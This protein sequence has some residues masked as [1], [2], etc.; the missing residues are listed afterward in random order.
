MNDLSEAA[1]AALAILRRAGS[2]PLPE[3]VWRSRCIA[4]GKLATGGIEAQR[5][6]FRRV[7]ERLEN[8]GI[9]RLEN[10]TVT[11]A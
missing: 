7:R 1:R 8:A 6:S 4:S 3:E 10:G 11:L 2:E 9:I 5:K